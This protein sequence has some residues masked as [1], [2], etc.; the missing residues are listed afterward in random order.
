MTAAINIRD[1]FKGFVDAK[2]PEIAISGAVLDSRDVCPGDLFFA[3]QGDALN[4][5]SFIDVAIQ[6]G[7]IA[8]VAEAGSAVDKNLSVPVI[9]L[10][11][12]SK[13]LP[14]LARRIYADISA[15]LHTF[16]VTGT[17]GK[18][19]CAHAYAAISTLLGQRCGSVGTI[20]W[21]VDG[22]TY[23]TRN[24]TPD[25]LTLHR[26]FA[27]MKSA[28]CGAVAMEMSSH[29]LQQRRADGVRVDV[30]AITNVTRDHLDYHGSIESYAAC[31]SRL[32]QWPD[33]KLAIVNYDDAL[34]RAMTSNC[35]KL[36]FSVAGNTQADVVASRVRE[37]A[38]GVSAMLHTPWGEAELQTSLIARYNVANLLAVITA[39][40]AAGHDLK[41]VVEA[42]A[43]FRGVAGRMQRVDTG[44]DFSI[45]VDYAHTPD[46]LKN[47]L[48]ALRPLCEGRLV[49]VFG[50]GGDR[51]AGK[52]ALMG[53]VASTFADISVVTS[54][55]P[56]SEEPSA[57]V[58]AILEGVK[59]RT[60][61]HVCLD[62]KAAIEEAIAG[63]QSGDIILIAGKGH[64]NYQEIDGRRFDFDDTEVAA[65]ALTKGALH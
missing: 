7:A 39:L 10:T 27:A 35:E 32:L 46:A 3:L 57:I 36:S 53:D 2:L 42:V 19:S 14:L 25:T 44:S 48:M 52:R 50:C 29:A 22:E 20:G 11:D 17:N 12:L 24:T 61:V 41:A 56:R 49:V 34:C 9:E 15:D 54:D 23:E 28:D 4:G 55:N 18:T 38:S 59:S 13:N 60:S 5:A 64:E 62:R 37:K 31:K 45:L 43:Q 33:L 26:I 6:K 65:T 1:V 58:D 63:A 21:G 16:A 40:V 51:D 47:A 30:A 8:V